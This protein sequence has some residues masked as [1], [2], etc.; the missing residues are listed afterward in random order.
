[1]PLK[2]DAQIEDAVK[3]FTDIMKTAWYLPHQ[4][5]LV[6]RTQVQP[7][8]QQQ[9]PQLQSDT[10]THLDIRHST[11]GYD[12]KFKHR[13][14]GAFSIQS[15]A[16]NSECPLVRAKFCHPQGPSNTNSKRRNQPIQLPL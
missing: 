8:S 7:L 11:L 15:P 12:L 5:V 9:S 16:A 4:D 14:F 3:C 10:Q 2:T 1:V 13:N 6:T